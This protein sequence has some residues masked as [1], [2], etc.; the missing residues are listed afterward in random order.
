MSWE[1][2]MRCWGPEAVLYLRSESVKSSQNRNVNAAKSSSQ[3][4]HIVPRTAFKTVAT[5]HCE[6]ITGLILGWFDFHSFLHAR[7]GNDIPAGW[8]WFSSSGSV[9]YGQLHFSMQAL[10]TLVQ[11]SHSVCWTRFSSSKI[12]HVKNWDMN[13]RKGDQKKK[14]NNSRGET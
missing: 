6:I 2:S 5:L 11:I 10:Q 12:H 7:A 1:V 13:L 3:G 4:M 14:G 8:S 9:L